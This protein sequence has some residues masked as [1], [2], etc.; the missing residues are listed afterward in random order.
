MACI[1]T[2]KISNSGVLNYKMQNALDLYI[3]RCILLFSCV[4]CIRCQKLETLAVSVACASMHQCTVVAGT[5]CQWSSFIV[6]CFAC[7]SAAGAPSSRTKGQA[8]KRSHCRSENLHTQRPGQSLSCYPY[9]WQ[10]VCLCTLT[11]VFWLTVKLDS[12]ISH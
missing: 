2:G 6:M 9:I 8:R 1:N 7:S 5:S 12:T 11:K 4:M 10:G 3:D